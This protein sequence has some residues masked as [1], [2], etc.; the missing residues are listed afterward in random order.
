MHCL[1]EDIFLM[2]LADHYKYLVFLCCSFFV[3]RYTKGVDMWS[4]GCILG[5]MLLGKYK[6]AWY[7]FIN[8]SK[9]KFFMSYTVMSDNCCIL[10]FNCP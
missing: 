10:Q 2:L 3:I 4:L 6:P 5:E 8:N 9:Q 7:V 1:D